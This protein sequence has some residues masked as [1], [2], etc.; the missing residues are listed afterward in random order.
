M[1]E[2]GH[3]LGLHHG[4]AVDEPN[5]APNYL[6]V[7]NYAFGGLLLRASGT[8]VLDYS[9]FEIPFDEQ[10][11]DETVG[12]DFSPGTAPA[13]FLTLY[14]CPGGAKQAAPLAAAE[15][16][17]DC[18]GS[19]STSPVSTDTNKDNKTT[20]LPSQTDWD[21]LIFDG[22]TIGAKGDDALSMLTPVD[23]LPQEE[24]EANAALL[25][26]CAAALAAGQANCIGVT[27]AVST[28]E[29]SPSASGATAAPAPT[30]S[31]APVQAPGPGDSSS[32]TLVLVGGVVVVI[33]LLGLGAL[34]LT[35]R[36]RG[37]PG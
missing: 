12:F 21:K 19:I 14:R 5:Y 30:A 23:E 29:P 31:A 13:E 24:L 28:G 10:D 6:S 33:I 2:L 36:W 11:L 20:E 27:A 32:S 1:H 26:A 8:G 16:D 22:G 25:Q 3:N 37:R 34:F 15:V 18:N 4:G 35:R 9:R 7:M 17:W